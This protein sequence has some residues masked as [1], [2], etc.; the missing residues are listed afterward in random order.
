MIKYKGNTQNVNQHQIIVLS[1]VWDHIRDVVFCNVFAYVCVFKKVNHNHR[2][3][4]PSV[5]YHGSIMMFVINSYAYLDILKQ[6]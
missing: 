1:M 2:V 6:I 3:W 4:R 5:A